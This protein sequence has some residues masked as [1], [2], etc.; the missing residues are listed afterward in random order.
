MDGGLLRTLAADHRVGGLL[1]L[2]GRRLMGEALS[3]AQR[4]AAERDWSVLLCDIGSDPEKS[5][6]QLA[7]IVA[8]GA[9]RPI[10]AETIFL[11][12]G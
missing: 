2:W 8:R 4:V 7:S 6:T 9:Q 1:A 5:R 10:D 11:V 3:Q 12:I